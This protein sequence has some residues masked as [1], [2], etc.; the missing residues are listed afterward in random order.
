MVRVLCE[1][2]VVASHSRCWDR[3]QT[4]TDPVHVEI[5]R[6]LRA[7]YSRRALRPVGLPRGVEVATRSL[8]DYDSVFGVDFTAGDREETVA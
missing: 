3:H 8:S 7:Q 5:A 6:S 4:I 1:G 2:T